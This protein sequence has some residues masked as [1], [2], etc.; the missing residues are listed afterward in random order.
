MKKV[1]ISFLGACIIGI[2]FVGISTGWTCSCLYGWHYGGDVYTVGC[3]KVLG[4]DNA[5]WSYLY[6]FVPENPGKYKIS[7]DFKNE[8]SDSPYNT[9]SEEYAFLDTFYATLYFVNSCSRFDLENC[10]C[11]YSIDLFDLDYNGPF[12]VYGNI[13]PSS[14]GDDWLHFD[15]VFS[16]YLYKIIPTFEL[17]NL[18]QENNDSKVLIAN[19]V[20]SQVPL[21]GTIFLLGSG[22]L[23]LFAR[24]FRENKHRG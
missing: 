1:A 16:N 5:G 20:I 23:G 10:S 12:N 15:M 24:K 22:L 13:T 18:N 7:F 3:D 4:D 14:K 21:P 8:L 2:F 17:F 11:D 6:K 9:D 19:V